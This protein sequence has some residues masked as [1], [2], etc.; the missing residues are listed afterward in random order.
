[1]RILSRYVFKEFCVPLVYTLVGF[2]SIYVL[3]ELFS[4]FGRL[5]A[6]D[7]GIGVIVRYFLSYFAPQFKW[8]APACLMLATL[9]TMWNFCRHSELIA[10]R[11]SGVG[12]FAIVK[13]LLLVAIAMAGFT[14]WVNESFVPE[15]AQWAKDFRAVK[16]KA[17]DMSISEG[18]GVFHNESA[19]RTWKWAKYLDGNASSLGNVLIV[20]NYPSGSRRVTVNAERADYRDGRWWFTSPKVSWFTPNGNETVSPAPDADSLTYRTFDYDETPR[21]FLLQSRD[22]LFYSIADRMRFL[23]MNASMDEKGRREFAYAIWA[24]IFSP[25]ACLVIT[26]FAI[27]AGVA[28]GRQSVFKGVLGALGMFFAFYALTV[29]C[30]VLAQ[31]GFMPPIPAAALPHAVFFVI[32]CILFNRQR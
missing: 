3:F 12:F 31:L 20:E 6:A 26:L 17:E 5:S 32:G 25:L 4:S 24:Q 28:T 2:F 19:G 15:N 30:M 9:Y 7:P 27:P 21:D 13:P 23:E 16:F 11:A 8:F 18:R 14:Y 22:E 29:G 10:M 1:M